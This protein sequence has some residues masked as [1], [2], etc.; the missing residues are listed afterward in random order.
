[1][2]ACIAPALLHP[3]LRMRGAV[4]AEAIE[5]R[6]ELHALPPGEASRDMLITGPAIAQSAAK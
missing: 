5:G 6:P 2:A 3:V 1:M 4:S